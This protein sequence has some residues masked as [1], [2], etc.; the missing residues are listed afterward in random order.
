MTA[1]R[2]TVTALVMLAVNRLDEWT[3]ASIAVSDGDLFIRTHEHRWCSG[4]E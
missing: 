1:S 2:I 3:H 4:G